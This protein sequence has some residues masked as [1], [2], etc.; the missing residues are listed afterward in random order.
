[1][2]D[3][4]KIHPATL[5]TNIKQHIPI[6]LDYSSAE[7][8]NWST[9]FKLHCRAYLVID[10][11]TKPNEKSAVPDPSD[12]ALWQRLDDIV[13]QWIYG[14]ISNDLL[15]SILDADDTALD[16]WTRL[17][18]FFHNNK[19]ARALNLDSQFTNTKLEN[20]DGVKSY[21]TRLKTLADSLKNVGDKVSDNRMALQL[22]K[23]LSDDYKAFRTSVR[24]IKPLPSFDELR[25][26]LELE[27]QSN[28]SD[29]A[30]EARDTALSAATAPPSPPSAAP[31]ARGNSS[32]GGGRK[33]TKGKGKNRG[34]P[35]AAQKAAPPRAATSAPSSPPLPYGQPPSSYGPAYM[36]PPP[37]AYWAPP[38]WA[39]PPCP[40]PTQPWAARPGPQQ[41]ASSSG[42]LGPRPQA[43]YVAP[44]SSAS[45]SGYVPTN[46][47]QAMYTMS[48]ADPNY[49]MDTGATSHMTHSEGNLSPYFNL[50]T[51][52]NN[53]I[54]VG[55]GSK[56]PIKGY[57]TISIPHN[58]LHLKNVLHVPK[59]VKNLISVRKFTTDNNVS[60]E[61]DPFGFS[62]KDLQ[63]G[64]SLVRCNSSGDLYPFFTK[65]QASGSSPPSAFAVVSSDLWHS[66]LGHP[67][68]NVLNSLR[69]SNFIECNKTPSHACHSC[70]L[71][72]L[73]KSPFYDS[74]NHTT[75]P[76]DIIH[77][78]LW[79]SPILSS[80]GHKYYVLFLDDYTN[81]LWTFP[82]STKS[83]V[84]NLF[85][86]IRTYIKTQFERDVKSF[87]CDNGR[88][89]KNKPFTTFCDHYGMTLRL[90]CP[91][92]SPQNGKAE[93]KIKTINNI[94]RTLLCHA[95]MPP[96]FWHHALEMATYLHNILPTKL[97]SYKTPTEILYNKTPNYSHLRVFGC[98][99]FP[100]FPSS[101]IH[102]LQS[103]STP[104]VFLGYPS[105]HRGYK[106]YD[107]STNEIFIAKHVWF[108][109]SV[110]PFS[111]VHTPT[112][113]TY[114]FL[115]DCT[116][117]LD[118]PLLK[119]TL[120]PL[121]DQGH[122]LTD[123][124][125]PP[126]N[127]GPSPVPSS[128]PAR[129][130]GS[131]ASIGPSNPASR[132]AS[133]Q[134]A[135]SPAHADL[136]TSGPSSTH[137]PNS[138]S[139]SPNSPQ[140]PLSS[141]PM[142][143]GLDFASGPPHSITQQNSSSQTQIHPMTTR[144]K[145]GIFKPNPKFQAL[146]ASTYLS[147][148]PKNPVHALRDPNWKVA[149]QEEYD[150]LIEN[151]TWE[152]VPRPSNANIIRS[153]WIFRHKMKSDGSF[154]RYKARL[155]GDG[156]TQREGIDCDETFSPV[157]KPATIRTVLSIA[158]SKSWSIHQLDVKNAFLHGHLNETVYMYQPLGF[159]D[160]ARPNH[161]CLLRKSLYGLKQAPR[162]W[163]QRF[164]TFVKSFGFVNS[165]SDTSLFIYHHGKATAYLL[166]Y[167]DDIVIT[168][169]SESL[170][171]QIISRL[172]SEFAM[173]DLGELS[174]FLGISV[175][176]TND[177][178]FLSQQTYAK[179]IIDRAGMSHCKPSPTPVDSQGK[180]SSL[181][182]APF[183]DPSLYRRLC[184]A[185]Q[186][187]TFT[188]PDISYA[189]QQV[190]LFM[191]A[192]TDAHMAALKRIIRY[193]QGTSGSGLHLYKSSLSSLVSYTDADWGGCPDTRRSTSGYC[194][195]L[196]DN[197]IS[198][199]SKRQPTLSKSSA[200]AEYRGVANV[201]SESCWIRNLLLELHCPMS[202]ATFVYCD[203][204]S[205][206]YLSSNPVHHQRTKHIEM[207]IH[208]VREKVQKG[209]VRVFH[210]PSRYQIADIFTKSLPRIL[211]LD[212]RDSLNVREPPVSTAG[213]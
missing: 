99:C 21:C 103:R 43:Y 88:E 156:K 90:S 73:I 19:S 163:Y 160:P 193:L 59:L 143:V 29:L 91:Y 189:V 209:E 94:V 67:G 203:N 30:D 158:L 177:G 28:A 75:M 139:S 32:R 58:K 6:V 2:V 112:A 15:N 95:S 86:K 170:R 50:R 115:G 10:H 200:E 117:P 167:V 71:G 119:T 125:S 104:C 8:N 147:P 56:I 107:M 76:F 45:S 44:P 130:A 122:E 54:V 133:S 53:A 145:H 176:R 140:T 210:V 79:T 47:E 205:A 123:P 113:H 26:M 97:L 208:F 40:Y 3:S 102:K 23:G 213:V 35:N 65:S 116:S 70:P 42:I 186:Y 174:Y 182:S 74:L 55:D 108:D 89:F 78:D 134:P 127:A 12:K 188:R 121:L 146:H 197:L 25:S 62:V 83:Q 7:Y 179:E 63:T 157:V 85:L 129:S 169:S 164:A 162:A 82:L 180:L 96:S 124:A 48:L 64:S 207:D 181:N 80:Q 110:F 155:V 98:L 135:G 172:S 150:A 131:P 194:V 4:S 148:I 199:S 92:T 87:Q 9:L 72:K 166:L 190:C 159:R 191:H 49:Y 187:L 183:A 120:I 11:I 69:S 136:D 132:S 68:N 171:Q 17:E 81:F 52:T 211:F 154:E 178:L 18:N 192:P 144:S 141:S 196:G 36:Q 185:L 152:L 46:I 118:D 111:K 114:D 77:S 20:F 175:S 66:R 142:S 31:P 138:F 204:V 101:K 126:A 100:L 84:Y 1:M 27:E 105:N 206:I 13:R 184:G 60:I 128:L 151:G 161:V 61:F 173:K 93:R 106:C 5:V 57:G 165:K 168:A 24:H 22:L 153:L 33:S 109:E 202:K 39:N 51:H 149:M 34:G 195:F 38:A 41:H 14:T 201:V 37:W 16:T 212:F 198:W 137:G